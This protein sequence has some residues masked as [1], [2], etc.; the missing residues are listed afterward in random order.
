MIPVFAI[1][2]AEY[3]LPEARVK[4]IMAMVPFTV[5]PYMAL[6][7]AYALAYFP[8]GIRLLVQMSS[9]HMDNL[10]PANNKAKLLATNP[11]AARL[12]GA[13]NNM[14][15]GYPF[16]AC[17]VLSA[18][19]AGV[20]K[21]VVSMY[22]GFF[23]VLRMAFTI[24]YIIQTNDAMAGLRTLSFLGVLAVQGKLFYLAAAAMN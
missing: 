18:L 20:S 14:L 22:C 19:Q 17:S 2:G 21:E 10:H 23:L 8:M 4:A 13:H 15:E 6:L 5:S 24:I 16:F 9:N 3:L 7:L 12:D 1:L 11:L